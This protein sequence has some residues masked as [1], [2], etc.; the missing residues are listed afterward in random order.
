M[1]TIDTIITTDRLLLKAMTPEL[2]RHVFE[3]YDDDA[4]KMLFHMDDSRLAQCKDRLQKGMSSY[5]TTFLYFLMQ[6]KQNG[7]TIGTAGFY[8]WFQEQDRAEIGYDMSNEAYRKQG[9]TKEAA[10]R[11]VQ[12]GFED[13]NL[14]RIEAF[15]SPKNIGSIKILEGLGMKYEGLLREHYKK[16]GRYEDS[17]CYAILKNEYNKQ[18]QP[19]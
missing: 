16:D 10:K 3:Q 1:E 5:A 17:A 14:H 13:M 11:I 7:N 19:M 8:R 12:Y 2:Y 18:A 6:D 15:A 9:L 4:L